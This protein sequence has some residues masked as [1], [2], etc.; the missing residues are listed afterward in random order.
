[1]AC[2]V[3]A[4]VDWFLNSTLVEK[5]SIVY[6]VQWQVQLYR[7]ASCFAF[8]LLFGDYCWCFFKCNLIW[9]SIS[10][11]GRRLKPV[12]HNSKVW[13]M[14]QGSI[15]L[16]VS[17]LTFCSWK[18]CEH[19]HHAEIFHLDPTILFSTASRTF[20][21]LSFPPILSVQSIPAF[22]FYALFHSSSGRDI[23]IKALNIFS[24]LKVYRIKFF[25]SSKSLPKT[26]S[27]V[28]G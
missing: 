23:P 6:W 19:G 11:H 12:S 4:L 10:P 20:P 18:F 7:Y 15:A 25:I 2:R 17:R 3:L 21:S 16:K 26:S 9:E 24:A 22:R 13:N 8:W 14:W 5:G 27:L 1:M 28:M